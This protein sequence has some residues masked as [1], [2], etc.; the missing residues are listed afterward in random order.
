MEIALITDQ[1]QLYNPRHHYGNHPQTNERMDLGEIVSGELLIENCSEFCYNFMILSLLVIL[2]ALLASV[3]L[4]VGIIVGLCLG[5]FNP[6]PKPRILIRLLILLVIS[7]YDNRFSEEREM[8]K[9]WDIPER[10]LDNIKGVI[11]NTPY[12]QNKDLDKGID[13]M[14]EVI[15]EG[16]SSLG[17]WCI[18]RNANNMVKMAGTTLPV[19]L[20]NLR[21]FQLFGENESVVGGHDAGHVKYE[22]WWQCP[23]V[24][25]NQTVNVDYFTIWFEDPSVMGSSPV[26]KS[27]AILHPKKRGG[28]F[29]WDYFGPRSFMSSLFAMLRERQV[30]VAL[31]AGIAI[32]MAIFE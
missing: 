10:L 16:L 30:A 2:S 28:K 12:L 29:R 20:D 32:A 14:M 24:R 27:L 23:V 7:G 9:D 19:V 13:D 18:I 21:H 5:L 4:P 31:I 8:I 6:G 15:S 11:K 17:D 25:E 22:G 1:Y 3:H 26:N